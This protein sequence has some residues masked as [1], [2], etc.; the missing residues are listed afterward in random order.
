MRKRTILALIPAL[1]LLAAAPVLGKC[2]FRA[3][4]AWPPAGKIPPSGHI[5]VEGYGDYQDVIETA[6]SRELRLVS[7]G[8]VVNLEV[9]EHYL[10]EMSVAQVLLR[11]LEALKTGNIYWLSIEGIDEG[12]RYYDENEWRRQEW[13]VTGLLDNDSP[14]WMAGPEVVDSRR[15]PYGCGPAVEVDLAV[16]LAE[17]EPVMAWVQI[18]AT[19]SHTSKSVYLI[20]VK[21]GIVTIGHGMCSGPFILEKGVAYNADV[22]LIDRSGNRSDSRRLGEPFRAP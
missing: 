7:E 17:K 15:I 10:G 20:P 6:E 13:L 8:H 22:I 11:P 14:V 2:A 12:F 19:G 1:V 4:W 18:Q 16:D 3:A 9:V 21:R 5:L